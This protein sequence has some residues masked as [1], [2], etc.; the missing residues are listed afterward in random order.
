MLKVERRKEIYDVATQDVYDDDKHNHTCVEYGETSL[1]VPQLTLI[2]H[3]LFMLEL[4]HLQIH[5]ELLVA[6]RGIA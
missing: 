6:W 1:L 5:V 2:D 3:Y 4:L